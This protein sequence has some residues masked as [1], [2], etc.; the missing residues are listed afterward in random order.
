MKGALGPSATAL[1]IITSTIGAL[2]AMSPDSPWITI[3][4]RESQKARMARFQI[5]F[6]EKDLN[7]DVFVSMLA[8]LIEAQNTVTQVL[9]F[10]CKESQASFKTNSAKVS[11]NRN[12]AIQL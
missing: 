11:I 3:F 12:A 1:A 8:C 4:S 7:A 10:K 6:V 9:V 5:G 2:K